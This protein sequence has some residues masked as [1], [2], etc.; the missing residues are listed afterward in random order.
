[1]AIRYIVDNVQDAV[2]FYTQHLGFV[3]HK[4]WGPVVILRKEDLELWVS[5]PLSSAGKTLLD[6]KKPLPG[7]SNRLV[8]TV[9]NL[10][11]TIERLK[12]SLR[13]T[14]HHPRRPSCARRRF[15]ADAW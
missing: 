4:N 6:N 1:M 3:I 15:S 9:T 10:Q 12:G 14:P 8:T 5:G 13:R 2:S 11:E 7:G